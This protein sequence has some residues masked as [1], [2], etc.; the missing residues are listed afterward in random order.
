MEESFRIENPEL[1]LQRVRLECTS[2]G[3]ACGWMGGYENVIRENDE[4]FILQ[5]MSFKPPTL[6]LKMWK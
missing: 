3:D 4:D 6:N 1:F 5:Q 2:R